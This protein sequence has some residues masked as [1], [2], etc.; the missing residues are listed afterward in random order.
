MWQDNI[1]EKYFRYCTENKLTLELGDNGEKVD[2]C[3]NYRSALNFVSYSNA[4]KLK[5]ISATGWKPGHG[6]KAQYF[7]GNY[8]CI[9]FNNITNNWILSEQ[10]SITKIFYFIIWLQQF[11]TNNQYKPSSFLSSQLWENNRI[12]VLILTFSIYLLTN[13]FLIAAK[14]YT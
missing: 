8:E 14:Q 13:T 2:L 12:K 1:E 9:K 4:L 7:I 3:G 6:F 11:R 5:T 10:L